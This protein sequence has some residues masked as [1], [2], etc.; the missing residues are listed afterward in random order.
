MSTGRKQ[1]V[2]INDIEL[3]DD[4]IIGS[5]SERQCDVY[6]ADR[7]LKTR[8]ALWKEKKERGVHVPPPSRRLCSQQ[9]RHSDVALQRPYCN[10]HLSSSYLPVCGLS[11]D[12]AVAS[13]SIEDLP[14]ERGTSE[15]LSSLGGLSVL[16]SDFSTRHP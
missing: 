4:D 16:F 10:E 12:L 11:E 3:W 6:L 2:G 15:C 7:Q 14:H 9:S 8:M 5:M 1:P 13:V